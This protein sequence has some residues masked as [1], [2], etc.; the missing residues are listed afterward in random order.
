[1]IS[2]PRLRMGGLEASWK[3]CCERHDIGSNT[4]FGAKVASWFNLETLTS[5]NKRRFDP[6]FLSAASISYRIE[7]PPPKLAK[8]IREKEATKNKN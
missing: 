4:T 2:V 7:P 5:L 6:L 3:G 1:M 8:H